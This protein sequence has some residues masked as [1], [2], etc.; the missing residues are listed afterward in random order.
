MVI[1]VS[2]FGIG[3]LIISIGIF[4]FTLYSLKLV[5][6]VNEAI[7]TSTEVIAETKATIEETNKMLESVNGVTNNAKE[8]T[9]EVRKLIASLS[10][11]F[12]TVESYLTIFKNISNFTNN[13]TTSKK[14]KAPVDFV[15]TS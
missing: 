1:E 14:D 8:M 5:K 7:I 11:V 3:F 9:D 10:E 6:S 2:L 13:L 12:K 15:K 4:I